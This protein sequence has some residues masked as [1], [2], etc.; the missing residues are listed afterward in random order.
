MKT[1]LILICFLLLLLSSA[2]GTLASSKTIKEEGIKVTEIKRTIIP[3][4]WGRI[5][6]IHREPTNKLI[7]YLSAPD[8]LRIVF[9]FLYPDN[10]EIKEVIK[11]R[12]SPEEKFVK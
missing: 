2:S 7:I 12:R 1:I 5:V 9:G 6:Q 10:F 11:I 3:E 8:A 4:S